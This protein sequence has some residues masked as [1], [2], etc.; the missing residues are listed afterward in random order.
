MVQAYLCPQFWCAWAHALP[1]PP[2]L[3]LL[4][5]ALSLDPV[6]PSVFASTFLAAAKP[7]ETAL[8]VSRNWGPEAATAAIMLTATSEAIMAYSM[9]VTPLVDRQ[10][11]VNVRI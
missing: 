4:W 2:P 10:G 9:A 1:L 5:F 6:P 8:N 7:A 3:V 11:R